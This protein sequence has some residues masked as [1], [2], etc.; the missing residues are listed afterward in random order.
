MNRQLAH[1][2]PR[3]RSG[4]LVVGMALVSAWLGLTACASGPDLRLERLVLESKPLPRGGSSEA[5][6]AYYDAVF[7]K[8]R[9]ALH[10]GGTEGLAELRFLIQQHKRDDMVGTAAT[11]MRQFE[12]LADGLQFE[13]KLPEL[14]SVVRTDASAPVG[15]TQ[16]FAVRLRQNGERVLE[17]GGTGDQEVVFRVV[18][19]L[20]DFDSSGQFVE[21]EDSVPLRVKNRQRL[22]AGAELVLPFELPGAAPATVIREMAVRVELLPCVVSLD[23]HEVPV[24]QSGRKR[25]TPAEIAQLPPK[26]RL[27]YST[28]GHT[29]CAVLDVLV[30]PKGYES[31]EKNPLATMREAQRRGD[32]KYF[33]HTFL[34]AHFMPTKDRDKAM[35]VLIQHVRNG[36]ASQARVAMGAL[37]LLS[38][39]EFEITERR[40]WLMWW[41]RYQDQIK[42]R[43]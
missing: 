25:L 30:Y 10:S 12:L 35:A 24:S 21:M 14:C 41:K 5:V 20:R 13:L 16:K 19:R 7:S 1:A 2:R 36:T 42:K 33:Q 4:W 8:M 34:A 17:C 31:V 37:R 38:R 28:R 40:A 23:G 15:A 11:R 26:D 29:P 39:E 27:L 22:T 18:V 3:Q 43:K 6:V 32:A 9:D